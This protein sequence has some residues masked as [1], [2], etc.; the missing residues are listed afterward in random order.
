MTDVPAPSG[1]QHELALGE[2]RA[3]IVEVGGGVRAYSDAGREVLESY[4]REAICDGG[5]GTP[6]FPW[7]NRL[8]GGRYEF[9]GR[10]YQLPLT[11]P[12]RG[13]AIH[14]L[15]RWRPWT[16]HEHEPERV[17][18]RAHLHPQPGYPFALA[19]SA[20]YELSESGLTVTLGAENVGSRPC[21]FAAGQH[22]YLATGSA[23]DRPARVDD[24]RLTLP[25]ASRLL[26]DPDS[27]LP[28]GTE[29]VAGTELDYRSARSL[30]EA[31]ID[32]PFTALVRGEDGL[33]RAQLERPDGAK[34]ELWVDGSF[35]HL[36]VF[37]GDTLEPQ[38]ARRGLAVEPMSSPPNA[39]VSGDGL[40][41]LAPGERWSAS[42]GVR[43]LR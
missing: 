33:A 18:M 29:P 7:P 36:E 6:L 13:N 4:P 14:G 34:L 43:L 16:A 35:T 24:C 9:D 11:E 17:L 30:G 38:R 8:A 21:P 5:H 41:R 10:S 22:P 15:M 20:A 23:G 37:T 3:T 25:A 42:W 32:T 27:G 40:L 19:L 39:F 12:A 26:I 1:T 31:R 28:V 2:Q